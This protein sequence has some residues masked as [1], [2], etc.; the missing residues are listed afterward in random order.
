MHRAEK[1]PSKILSRKWHDKELMI[2][3]QKLREA[4]GELSM[5]VDMS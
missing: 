5:S 1:A 2:H 3:K 4:K